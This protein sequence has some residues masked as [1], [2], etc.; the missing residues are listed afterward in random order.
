MTNVAQLFQPNL[1]T[2]VPTG[3]IGEYKEALGTSTSLTTSIYNVTSNAGVSLSPGIWDIQASCVINPNSTST[4]TTIF[5]F[6]ST[7]TANDNTGI[8]G[9]RNLFSSYHGGITNSNGDSW[10]VSTPMW[11]VNVT[12]TTTYYPKIYVNF[13]TSTCTGTA[14]IFARRVN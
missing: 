6:I 1:G 13:G 8:D 3:Y 10:R 7:T 12:S 5:C 2:T 9:N 14:N 4:L 11:R